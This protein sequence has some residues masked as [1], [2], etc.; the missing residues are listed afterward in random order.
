MA[1]LAIFDWPG[2][3]K[4]ACWGASPNPAL[5]DKMS[6]RD[7]LRHRPYRPSKI[8]RAAAAELYPEWYQRVVVEGNKR[9]AK[10]NIGYRKK[11]QVK[12][13]ALYEWWKRRVTEIEGG[14]RYFYLMCLVIYA[15][16]CDVPKKQLK[17]DM[18]ECFDVLRTYKHDNELTQEDV[19]SAME[20]YSKDYYNFTIADIEILTDVRIERNKRNGRK[21]DVHCNTNL[22]IDKSFRF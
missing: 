8:D 15:C 12:D 3:V 10:W 18:Q 19:D 4:N 1:T 14:H 17:A 7:W 6:Q 20:C 9:P 2:A 22:I 21:Q 16:K 13:Y 11:K 5:W